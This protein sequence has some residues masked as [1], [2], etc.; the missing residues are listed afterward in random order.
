M[1]P[2]KGICVLAQQRNL[3]LYNRLVLGITSLNR[4]LPAKAGQAVPRHDKQTEKLL[5]NHL[6]QIWLF[7]YFC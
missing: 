2:E 5:N 6:L 4:F 1:L 3:F 7:S